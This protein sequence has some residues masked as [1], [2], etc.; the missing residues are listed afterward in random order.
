MENQLNFRILQIINNQIRDQSTNLITH[1][2]LNK[3]KNL[4]PILLIR[5]N[6]N[7][8]THIP[9]RRYSPSDRCSFFCKFS[10]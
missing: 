9:Q 8:T 7:K 3:T 10:K 4:L 5:F 6:F 1:K 2:F